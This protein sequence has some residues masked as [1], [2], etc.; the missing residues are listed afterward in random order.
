MEKKLLILTMTLLFIVTTI[1]LVIMMKK[2][3]VLPLGSILPKIAFINNKTRFTIIA[4]IAE[5]II[6]MYFSANCPHCTY[7]IKLLDTN[8]Q[9]MNGIKLYLFTADNIL[10]EKAI[11]GL[12]GSLFYKNGNVFIG[13]VNEEEFLNKFGTKVTPAFFVFDRNKKLVS[14]NYGEI[15]IDKLLEPIRSSDDAQHQKSGIK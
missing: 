13:T 3:D 6:V 11:K 10:N 5:P 12:L 2:E 9:K 14:K 1:V 15:K 8:C 4:D 7:Q